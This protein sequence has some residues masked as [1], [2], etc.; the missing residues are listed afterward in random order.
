MCN[1][2]YMSED[3]DLNPEQ[4]H[5]M[6]QVSQVSQVSMDVVLIHRFVVANVAILNLLKKYTSTDPNLSKLDSTIDRCVESLKSS[7]FDF[8]KTLRKIYDALKT[9]EA[10]EKIKNADPTLFE[11]RN[12]SNKIISILPGINIK[13]VY[14]Y[15]SEE[16]VSMFWQYLYL[17]VLSTFNIFYLKNS[18][19][20]NAQSNVVDMLKNIS[21]KVNESI[22]MGDLMFNPYMGVDAGKT[23][24]DYTLDDLFAQTADFKTGDQLS[25]LDGIL[26]AM[27]INNL[28]SAINE[29]ELNSK[30]AALNDSDLQMATEQIAN[31]L[32]ASNDPNAQNVCGKLVKNLVSELQTKGISNVGEVLQ[33]VS[34]NSR[35]D[36]NVTEMQQTMSYVKNFM[37]SGEERLKDLK[38]EKGKP[39]DPQLLNSIMG[40]MNMLKAMGLSPK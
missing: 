8:Q 11:M 6:S 35:S 24:E 22:T 25:Y 2:I 30:L 1:T 19:K 13:Q 31:I 10:T 23:R 5:Q 37:D 4:S 36:I 34:K 15:L 18:K 33:S 17:I 39:I 26:Q 32:G 27:G 16:D 28:A 9:V 38:D 12:S 7:S 29:D 40:P 21:S 14:S 20:I 3:L